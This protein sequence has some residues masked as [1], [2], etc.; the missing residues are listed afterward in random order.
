MHT[1]KN[2]YDTRIIIEFVEKL[3]NTAT[4]PAMYHLFKKFNEKDVKF[5]REEKVH[6]LHH[7]TMQLLFLCKRPRHDIQTPVAFLTARVKKPDMYEWGKS[8]G[9]SN[10]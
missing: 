10:I 8:R 5:L 4:S 2:F 3:V 1:Q 9:F 6:E 7:I